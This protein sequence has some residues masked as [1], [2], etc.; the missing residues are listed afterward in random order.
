MCSVLEERQ[1]VAIDL[2]AAGRTVGEIAAEL[3]IDR[4][5]LWRWRRAPSFAAELNVRRAEIWEASTDRMRALVPRALDVVGR[6]V[7]EG[8]WRAAIAI[9]RL[10]RLDECG[11]DR[12][13]P[14][15]AQEL[16][17]AE[18]ADEA[19]RAL[20]REEEAVRELERRRALALRRLISV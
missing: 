17:D 19:R 2:L 8:N 15:V 14:T 3:G 12:F 16:E 20:D 11:L 1:R 5:T 18:A 9:L 10:A 13:G 7:D 6:E 4:S